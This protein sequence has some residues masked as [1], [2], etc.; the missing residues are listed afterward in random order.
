MSRNKKRSRGRPSKTTNLGVVLEHVPG[1]D[2]EEKLRKAFEIVFAEKEEP[3]E[4][5][6]PVHRQPKLWE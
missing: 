4:P 5:R 2:N 1:S 6:P 3:P